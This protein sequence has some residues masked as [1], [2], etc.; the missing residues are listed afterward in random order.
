MMEYVYVNRYRLV[1]VR[2]YVHVGNAKRQVPDQI[3]SADCHRYV[4]E[5]EHEIMELKEQ[6]CALHR[7]LVRAR[8]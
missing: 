4:L 8:G 2:S 7:D 1:R 3:E 6:V 5:L